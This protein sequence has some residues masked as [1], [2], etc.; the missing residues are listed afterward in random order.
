M[1]VGVLKEAKTH[2]YRVSV[3]PAG[4]DELVRRGHQVLVET[5]AGAGSGLHDNEYLQAGAQIV[6]T[7]EQIYEKADLIVKVK[8]PLPDEWP[9]MGEGQV[10]FTYFHLAAD[11]KLTEGVLETGCVAVAY[12]T[13]TDRNGSLPLLTP[14]SE[15]AGRMS[16]QEGAK[17]LEKPSMGRGMLL[18]GIPG[19]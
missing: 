9:L 13:I 17:Y 14:M 19:V 3:V 5:Q 1:K 15:V 6:A 18:G 4:V 8:E 7:R 11:R 12:E 16:I 10:M 2:E